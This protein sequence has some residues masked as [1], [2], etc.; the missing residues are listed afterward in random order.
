[1][2]CH[3]EYHRIP[4]HLGRL[5]VYDAKLIPV[6]VCSKLVDAMND[7]MDRNSALIGYKRCEYMEDW[8]SLQVVDAIEQMAFVHS[9]AKEL[10]ER[11][12]RLLSRLI[13]T[14]DKHNKNNS[15]TLD[16][17]NVAAM[18]GFT[19][20]NDATRK[21]QKRRILHGLED[22]DVRLIE[23]AVGKLSI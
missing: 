14:G 7:L 1:M 21:P 23:N 19:A 15:N 10:Q 6:N 17:D 9:E 18:F 22:G 8:E 2:L 12:Q 11:C 16:I 3:Q 13:L 4:L 5:A 20:T